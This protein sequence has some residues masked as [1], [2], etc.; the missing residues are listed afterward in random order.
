[1]RLGPA[2]DKKAY[3]ELVDLNRPDEESKNLLLN[4]M[5]GTFVEPIQDHHRWGLKG[6]HVRERFDQEP[7]ELYRHC[8]PDH[9]R[10]TLNGLLKGH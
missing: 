2:R 8:A 9:Q 7:L 3:G 5:V 6:G 10:I 1:M 4:F